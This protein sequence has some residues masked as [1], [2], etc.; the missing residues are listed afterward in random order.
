MKTWRWIAVAVVVGMALGTGSVAYAQEETPVSVCQAGV[1]R[2]SG[3]GQAGMGPLHEYMV[4]A[5][6]ER[7]GLALA[8]VEDRLAAGETLCDIALDQGL[9]LEDF[10]SLWLDIRQEAIAEAVADGVLTEEQAEWLS[11][12]GGPNASGPALSGSCKGE[13]S[14]DG[15]AN[16]FGFGRRIGG[17]RP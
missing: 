12:R 17:S 4:E 3:A 13:M 7:L 5:F 9:S 1:R 15:L 2:G 8:T 11:Q 14:G 16:R 10:R 6:A